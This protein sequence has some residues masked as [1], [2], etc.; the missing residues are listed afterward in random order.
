MSANKQPLHFT[1]PEEA[2]RRAALPFE[3]EDVK[4]LPQGVDYKAKTA[5]AAAYADKRTYT[6][7]MDEIFGHQ[8]WQIQ[9]KCGLTIPGWKRFKERKD[10]Q[11]NI[12]Q[13]A[14]TVQT[15]KLG[16]VASCGVY[17]GPEHGWVWKDS[18]GEEDAADEN[19]MT[20]AEKQCVARAF[21]MWGPGNYFYALGKNSYPVNAPFGGAVTFSQIPQ[22]PDFGVPNHCTDCY[23]P[24]TATTSPAMSVDQVLDLSYK[25]F[26]RRMCAGCMK[27]RKD[28]AKQAKAA[29]TAQPVAKPAPAT[30][31]N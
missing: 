21:A 27:K 17:F 15:A 4:W 28:A 24:V 12:T 2:F 23:L 9:I 11:G 30:P 22:M 29:Q 16:M 19:A 25:Y 6:A 7:R 1:D 13:P 3:L 20:A 10:K 8:N 31:V 26:N 14:E 18:T 5:I